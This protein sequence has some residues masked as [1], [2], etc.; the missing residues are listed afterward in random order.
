MKFSEWMTQKAHEKGAGI[1]FTDGKK[2]LLLKRLSSHRG[3]WVPPGGGPEENEIPIETA[4]R[5]SKEE[6]G[7]NKGKALVK[8]KSRNGFYTF[9][10]RLN[11][12]FK[13]KISSEH[14][15]AKWVDIKDVE[16]YKLHPDFKKDWREL[17]N[18]I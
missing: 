14:S 7:F 12:T 13:P 6:C 16:K 1:L 18:L 15:E 4:R 5:E 8:F 10:V 11:K 3:T 2:V 9:V 17:L